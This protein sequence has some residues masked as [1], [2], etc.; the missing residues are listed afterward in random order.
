MRARRVPAALAWV[1]AVTAALAHLGLAALAVVEHVRLPWL[2]AVPIDL[3]FVTVVAAS[4]VVGLVGIALVLLRVV[5]GGRTLRRVRRARTS[6]PKL[7]TDAAAELG[8]A[9]RV[10]VVAQV[11]PFA[12][13]YGLLRPRILL[14]TGLLRVLSP[15]ELSAV[16]AHEREHLRGRD[17]LRLLAA[18]LLAGYAWYLPLGGWIAQRFAVRRELAAD[19][20]ATVHAGTAA[21]AGALLKLAGGPG[22]VAGAGVNPYDSLEARISQL[23][24]R[25][26]AR[27]RLGFVPLVATVGNGVLLSFATLCCVGLAHTLSGGVG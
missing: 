16:L 11:E 18:R 21:M 6:P 1:L 25:R 22:L 17:P 13:T 20:A 3:T 9:H 12:F 23:E 10:D 4:G 8:V 26:A 2:D 15:E 5:K 14:T 7:L 19:L 24:G 27:R